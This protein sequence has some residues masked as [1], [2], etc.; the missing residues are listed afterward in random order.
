MDLSLKTKSLD[1]YFLKTLESIVKR[2]M[3]MCRDD[4]RKED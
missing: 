3:S 4:N 1:S 2:M